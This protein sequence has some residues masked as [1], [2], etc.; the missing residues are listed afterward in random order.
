[1]INP[2]ILTLLMFS[3]IL[4][5]LI[6]M[7]SSHWFMAWLGLEINYLAMIPLMLQ[8]Y[9]HRSVEAAMKYFLIQATAS[10]TLL[11]A[12][13]MNIWMFGVWNIQQTDKP[14]ILFMI[15]AALTLKLGLAPF[16]TWFPEVMQGLTLP[17]CLLLSTW[18]KIAPLSL[19][20]QLPM[21]YSVIIHFIGLLSIMIGGWGGLNQ[22]QLP[23]IMGYSAIAHFGWMILIIQQMPELTSLAFMIYTI[24]TSS[25][26][27][28][29][30]YNKTNN[31][32]SLS[33]TWTKMPIILIITPLILFSLGGL[34]PLTGFLPKW[35]I[36]LEL[37]K[38]E[39]VLTASTAA[40]LALLTLYFYVRLSF[41]LAITTSPSILPDLMPWRMMPS[42][43][44]HH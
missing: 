3:L 32:T 25:M 33:I 6:T 34:P 13:A 19:L 29:F 40:V 22:T 9:S 17:T 36:L 37:A 14:V 39:F 42:H 16:H 30:W 18:Q 10:S 15:F 8:K 28:M 35:M 4:G 2:L 1:M 23:K 21:K 41:A 38:N 24:L 20:I 11:F 31:I 44:F 27:L 43:P 26:F 12:S 5:T 7:S